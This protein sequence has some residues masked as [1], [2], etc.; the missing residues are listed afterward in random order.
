VDEVY[1]LKKTEIMTGL[2]AERLRE[3]VMSGEVSGIQPGGPRGK[4]FIPLSEIERLRTPVHLRAS[5]QEQK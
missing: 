4:L 2:S 3:M 1:D 5:Q